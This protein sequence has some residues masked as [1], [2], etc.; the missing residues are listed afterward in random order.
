MTI[1]VGETLPSA[2]FM[3]MTSGGPAPLTTEELTK[4]RKVVIFG[5]PGAFTPTCDRNHLPGF[6]AKYDEFKS[7]GVDE[8]AVVAVNDVFVMHA[9]ETSTES[10][11]KIKFLADGSA[12]FTRAVGLELDASGFGMGIRSQRYSMLVDDGVVKVLNIEEVPTEAAA[13]GAEAL[14]PAV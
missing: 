11:G 3:T 2:S 12:A 6:L 10:A 1:S 8:V 4:G 14:L 9:W 5:V 13:S 7:K